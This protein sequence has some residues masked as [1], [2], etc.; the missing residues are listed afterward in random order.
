MKKL[1]QLLRLSAFAVAA[2]CSTYTLQPAFQAQAQQACEANLPDGVSYNSIVNSLFPEGTLINPSYVTDTASPNLLGV[3]P[4]TTVAVTFLGYVSDNTHNRLG[5]FLYDNTNTPTGVEGVIFEDAFTTTAGQTTVIGPFPANSNIGFY[6][7]VDGNSALRFFSLASLNEIFEGTHVRHFAAATIPDSDGAIAFG[8]E[9]L[10]NGG[11]RDYNDLVYA[12]RVCGT[13]NYCNISDN[14]CDTSCNNDPDCECTPDQT[15]NRS[16]G[17][18][19]GECTAGNQSRTCGQDHRWQAWG[20]CTGAV[21]NSP[22]VC[23]GLDNDCDG[24][25]DEELTDVGDACSTGDGVLGACASTGVT[26]CQQ[27]TPTCNATP[28]TPNTE[29]CDQIDNDCDGEVDE[30][31]VCEIEECNRSTAGSSCSVGVGACQVTGT[32]VCTEAGAVCDAIPGTPSNEICD[33]IDNDC[34][35]AIDED[36]V[37]RNNQCDSEQI[38]N[39]CVVGTGACQGSGFVSCVENTLICDAQA[40]E[41]SSEVCDSLDNDCDGEV[42]EGLNCSDTGVTPAPAVGVAGAGEFLEGQG[43]VMSATAQANP[44][45]YGLLALSF[46][47]I[48]FVRRKNS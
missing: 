9:D 43:C 20:E 29:I 48:S 1:S 30:G 44:A 3:S 46:G 6:I 33:G 10:L 4:T 28:G 17:S 38:G 18:D 34:D 32:T 15:D 14:V 37:C 27:G 39:P 26:V 41:G 40:T 11:D 7:D 42:D 35:G 31:N 25:V 16:C 45:I 19:V 24:D 22:E 12:T 13:V 21:A 36:G 8:V 47:L 23:D 5:Y 2:L